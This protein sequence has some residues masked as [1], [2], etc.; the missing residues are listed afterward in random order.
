MT[1]D[2]WLVLVGLF[3][4]IAVLTAMG[5]SAVL[6]RSVPERR[7]LR[8]IGTGGGSTLSRSRFA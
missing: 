2:L 6:A 1:P 5:A 3:A 7:R 8:E 4:S